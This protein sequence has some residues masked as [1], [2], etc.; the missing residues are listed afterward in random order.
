M[1]ITKKYIIEID[2]QEV[3]KVGMDFK[4]EFNILHLIYKILM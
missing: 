1:E 2:A 3:Y 4:N